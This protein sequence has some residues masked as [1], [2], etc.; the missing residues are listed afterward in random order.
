MKTITVLL[1]PVLLFANT[2][3]IS[4]SP[5]SLSAS[6]FTGG[7]DT[8]VVQ[9][10]N[11]GNSDLIYSITTEYE[12]VQ[13]VSIEFLGNV[14]YP[15]SVSDVWGY[16]A[17]DGTELAIVGTYTGTSFIEVSTDPAQPTEV[18]FITGPSS[19]W[20]DIKTYSHYAYIVTEGGGGLQIVDLADPQNPVLATTYTASFN[21][22]HNL[23]I[24]E[25]GFAYIVGSDAANGGLH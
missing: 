25:A 15:Q 10:G 4:V 12:G 20:R 13:A 21:S 7:M 1:L 24:D 3:E 18:G 6:L 14:D 9:I 5:D 17:P 11:T 8:Q 2:P 22:A 19:S 23:F 16:T